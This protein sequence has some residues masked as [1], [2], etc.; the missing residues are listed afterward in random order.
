MKLCD[1]GCGLEAKFY[2]KS[3]NKWC[4][5]SNTH[6]CPEQKKQR[7]KSKYISEKITNLNTK[8]LCDYGCG[9]IAL[10]KI[11]DRKFCCSKSINQCPDKRK[12]NSETSKGQVPWCKG[13][14]GIHSKE[15]L[16]RIRAGSK[17]KI[18]SEETHIK[19]SESQTLRNKK[20]V[21]PMT[22]RK[23]KEDSKELMR[24][25]RK[26]GFVPWNKGK[27]GL[28]HQSEK[29]RERSRQ[30]CLNGHAVYMNSFIKNPSKPQVELFNRIK[31]MYP[32]AILNY[33]L[34]RG[35]GKHDYSLDIV[36]TELMI[37]FESDGTW[38]HQ[39]KEKDLIRQKEIEEYGWRLIKY[40]PVDDIK[41]V[42]SIEQIKK[43]IENIIGV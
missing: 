16:E 24:K 4:C 9:Q 43:D 11:G 27:T 42:P 20:Y 6:R 32:T 5:E 37:W 36:I 1:Y 15:G 34:Y 29:E 33:P 35:K 41:Q 23:Q 8:I 2:F 19:M 25:N 31:E 30:Y 14:K 12:R 28:Q 26:P 18:I 13:K 39:D 38:W 3:T 17:N 7:K 21:N 40:Y 22:G 10:Y